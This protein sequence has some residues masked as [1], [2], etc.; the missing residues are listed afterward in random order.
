S[1]AISGHDI[2]HGEADPNDVNRVLLQI[3]QIWPGISAKYTGKALVSNW[4][5]NPFSKGA[6]VSPGLNTMTVWWGAQWETEANIYFAGEACDEEFWSYMEGAIRSGERVA[7]E[8]A[9][10]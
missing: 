7:K 5:G 8:I 4:W 3:E 10:G 9:Q 1:P 6:F 2:Y